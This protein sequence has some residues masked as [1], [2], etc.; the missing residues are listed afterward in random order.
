LRKTLKTALIRVTGNARAQRLLERAMSVS[1]Y[2]MGVGSGGDTDTSGERS[3]LDMVRARGKPVYRV[4]DVGANHGQYATLVLDALGPAN[5]QLHCFEPSAH[6]FELLTQAVQ[7]G[8]RVFLNRAAVGR[9]AGEAI[10]HSD[11]PGSGLASLTERRLDHF[12][13][14]MEQ[15]EVVPVVTI[16]DY[17][18][19]NRIDGIDLLKIDVEGHELDVLAGATTMLGRGAIDAIAFEFGGGNIDTRTFFQDFFYQ[20]DAAGMAIHRITPSG[21]L[22]PILRYQEAT[23]Q[24]RTTNYLAL[25][26]RPATEGQLRTPATRGS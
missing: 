5:V 11:A 15:S 9:A 21:Y 19:R 22:N 6:T 7:A 10:L 26:K 20:L 12:G 2:L 17:C 3:V 4:F 14:K 24:F 18:A 13:I 25:R 23:E 1:Q 8:D 16:D